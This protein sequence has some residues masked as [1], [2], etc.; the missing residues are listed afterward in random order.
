MVRYRAEYVRVG[1]LKGSQ[2]ALVKFEQ[3]L[4]A[5]TPGQSWFYQGD[6]VYGGALFRR[7]SCG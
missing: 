4:F 2:Q 7:V 5:V 3:P 6:A 1:T